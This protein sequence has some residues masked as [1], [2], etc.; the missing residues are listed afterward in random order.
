MT[1]NFGDPALSEQRFRDALKS[2]T[3]DDALVLETQIARTY[4]LREDFDAA[5]AVLTSIADDIAEAGEEARAR[6][7]LELGR[8]YASHR[9]APESLGPESR[10]QARSAFS[11]SLDISK[12]AKLDALSI[13]A[14][15]M[16]VFVD[17][18]PEEQLKWNLAAL[19]LIAASDQQ[20]AK[21][22]EASISSN[23]GEALYDLGRYEEALPYFRR[24]LNLREQQQQPQG[25]R[26]A[27]WHI[28]RVL[29]MQNKLEAPLE[30]QLRI[31]QESEAA[32][33]PRHYLFEEL[34]LLYQAKGTCSGPGTT[35]LGRRRSS[36]EW[37]S[38][39]Q[40][41]ADIDA[42]SIVAIGASPAWAAWQGPKRGG[43]M[44]HHATQPISAA[45][46]FRGSGHGGS[47][48]AMSS[49]SSA[50][51]GHSL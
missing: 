3:G 22:W 43:M 13:D 29:R 36:A 40:V 18:A 45:Y 37:E 42:G 27:N 28:A 7:W 14:M 34:Q 39:V 33:R 19:S 16:F 4:A 46:R 6:Y 21:R 1:Q 49:A 48:D 15:H 8:T 31:E 9:H 2:A 24:T 51:G 47:Q 12:Q 30:I 10:E 25:A 32:G 11:K 44:A 17:P 26:D 5:R 50:S 20:D 41:D 35:K 38:Q 23:T